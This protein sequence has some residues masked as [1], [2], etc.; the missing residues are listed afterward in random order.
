M[1]LHTCNYTGEANKDATDRSE[2]VRKK[3]KEE[4]MTD[5]NKGIDIYLNV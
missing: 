2:F 1:L 4:E 3:I 5:T